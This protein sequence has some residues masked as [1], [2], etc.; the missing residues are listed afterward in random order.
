[1]I[2]VHDTSEIALTRFIDRWIFVTYQI[3]FKESQKMSLIFLIL[4]GTISSSCRHTN[5]TVIKSSWPPLKSVQSVSC[6]DWP[7]RRSELEVK[8]IQAGNNNSSDGFVVKVKTRSGQLE[9]QFREIDG[10]SVESDEVFKLNWGLQAEYIGEYK[11]DNRS[12]FVIQRNSSRGPAIEIRN[13]IDNVIAHKT[14]ALP[15]NFQAESILSSEKGLW[16]TYKV[17]KSEESIDD[18]TTQLME[19]EVSDRELVKGVEYKGLQFSPETKVVALDKSNLFVM[20]RDSSLGGGRDRF[21]YQFVKSPNVKSPVFTMSSDFKEKVESWTVSLHRDGILAVFVSGDTLL[22][23]NANLEYKF[24][25]NV[26]EQVWSKSESIENEHVGDP[27]LVSYDTHSYLLMP[28]WLDGESTLS[29]TKVGNGETQ[30]L[31]NFGVFKEGTFISAVMRMEESPRPHIIIR[32]PVS[33]VKKH[34]ICEVGI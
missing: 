32:T 15:R 3:I 2:S 17:I 26:G 21:L 6:K 11:K 33:F 23:E 7:L 25:D 12:Y 28:K 5:Q 9:H 19:L 18:T 1:M 31:G 22:W 34:E 27:M 10:T 29:V 20:W 4:L 24:F 13:P 14:K 16:L 8:S 30:E